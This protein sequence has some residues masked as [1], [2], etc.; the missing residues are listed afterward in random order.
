MEKKFAEL[1]KRC[2]DM[3]AL[4]SAGALL[5]WDQNTYMPS[6]GAEGGGCPLN[7]GGHKCG[8]GCGCGG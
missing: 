4:G 7:P 6:G 3:A 8:G 1:R 2:E 5:G